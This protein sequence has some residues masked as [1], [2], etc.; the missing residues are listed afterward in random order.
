MAENGSITIPDV[1]DMMNKGASFDIT[2]VSLDI[3]RNTGGKRISLSHCIRKGSSHSTKE[4]GTITLEELGRK[5]HPVTI[6]LSLI[7]KFNGKSVL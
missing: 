2:Y 5:S 3:N 1:L 6:H 7:E 4:N